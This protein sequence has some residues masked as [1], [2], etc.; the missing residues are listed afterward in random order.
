VLDGERSLPAF[1]TTLQTEGRGANPRIVRSDRFPF[2][3]ARA[4]RFD[5]LAPQASRYY[6]AVIEVSRGC[7][8]LCEFCD[9][10]VLPQ[11][12]ETP[13]KDPALIVEDLLEPGGTERAVVD[14]FEGLG[15]KLFGLHFVIELGFLNGRS[16]FEGYDVKS[17]MNYSS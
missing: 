10:R 1:L 17:L 15:G 7:P 12:N 11:N 4:I 14:L 16:K 6:G 5:L 2:G 8:F 9:I 13:V 3:D